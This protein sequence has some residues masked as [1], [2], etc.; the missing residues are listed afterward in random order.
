MKF[1]FVPPDVLFHAKCLNEETMPEVHGVIDIMS[2]H[3][4]YIAN[5]VTIEEKIPNLCCGFFLGRDIVLNKVASLCDTVTGPSTKEYILHVL[6]KAS[7]DAI[8]LG[9]GGYSSLQVCDSKV[10]EHMKI[11][12]ELAQPSSNATMSQL[13]FF[14][15]MIKIAQDLGS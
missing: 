8:D 1:F 4:N 2:T 12:R 7:S 9:C 13:S 11:L 3:L 10:P 15:P 6:S 14:I 5:N